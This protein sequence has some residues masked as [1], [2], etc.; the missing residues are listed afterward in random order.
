[1]STRVQAERAEG[2]GDRGSLRVSVNQRPLMRFRRGT[3]LLN[4]AV[5]SNKAV[6]AGC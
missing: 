4:K 3:G 1:L 6:E 5:A 2:L